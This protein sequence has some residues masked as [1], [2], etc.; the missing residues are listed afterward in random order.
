MYKHILLPTD[1]SVLAE[2]AAAAGIALAAAV[3]ARVTALH[4]LPDE[5]GVAL[6]SWAH[7]AGAYAETLEQALV[8]RGTEYVE[9]IREA[10]RYAGV[11]CQCSLER[12]ASVHGAIASAARA[13]ECDLIVMGSK[14]HGD[15]AAILGSETVQ[16]LSMVNIAV[17]VQPPRDRLPDPASP[18][19]TSPGSRRVP[20]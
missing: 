13:N 16:A 2:R 18:P 8:R 17:L 20:A 9:N 7:P 11:E 10:A 1:G 6:D 4:V 19:G 14:A 5:P 15:A 12:A 3:G